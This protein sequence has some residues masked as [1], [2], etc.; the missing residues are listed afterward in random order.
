MTVWWRRGRV[1]TCSG[2]RGEITAHRPP[3]RPAQQQLGSRANTCRAKLRVSLAQAG[4][5]GARRGGAWRGLGH[6][7]CPGSILC[8]P[9]P[10]RSCPV[11]WWVTAGLR[12]VRQVAAV[13]LTTLGSAGKPRSS[14]DFLHGPD[15][16]SQNS[17]V[18]G[19]EFWGRG[20]S[21]H[22]SLM[23][24][25]VKPGMEIKVLQVN[26]NWLSFPS[27]KSNHPE[28]ECTAVQWSLATKYYPPFALQYLDVLLVV[29]SDNQWRH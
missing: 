7:A 1:R 27:N 24:E 22:P 17:S 21:H 4:G 28:N 14:A 16:S 11:G 26:S 20:I 25:M 3:R 13:V 15:S 10:G 8:W 12:W 18:P 19:I 6:P 5:A 9:H 2:S 29:E 23:L